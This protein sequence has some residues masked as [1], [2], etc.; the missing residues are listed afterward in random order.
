MTHFIPKFEPTWK[1][2]K[3]KSNQ[4]IGKMETPIVVRSDRKKVHKMRTPK[5]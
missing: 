1:A 3:G 5:K 2:D 4:K